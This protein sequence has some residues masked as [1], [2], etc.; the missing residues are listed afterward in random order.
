MP[1][2]DLLRTMAELGY[3]TEDIASR[4]QALTKLISNADGVTS[5]EDVEA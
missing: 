3:A 4:T 1:L 2:E 5:L